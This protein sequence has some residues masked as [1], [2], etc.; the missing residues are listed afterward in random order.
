MSSSQATVSSSPGT[1]S[2]C[3]QLPT[4]LDPRLPI[5]Y[6][7]GVFLSGRGKQVSGS[8]GLVLGIHSLDAH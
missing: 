7:E 3:H 5:T 2:A 6:R 4:L 8:S 1:V